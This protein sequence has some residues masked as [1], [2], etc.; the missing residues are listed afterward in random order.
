[1]DFRDG[2]DT[3]IVGGVL[4]AVCKICGRAI[5]K[6]IGVMRKHYKMT[7]AGGTVRAASANHVGYKDMSHVGGET[8]NNRTMRLPYAGS[9]QQE[10][11]FVKMRVTGPLSATFF[12]EP[13]LHTASDMRQS[14]GGMPRSGTS[15]PTHDDCRVDQ[16]FHKTKASAKKCGEPLRTHSKQCVGLIHH[17][18]E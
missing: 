7:H 2:F 14:G 6:N 15:G 8:T 5:A 12:T 9:K 16:Q 11:T 10:P 17:W 13:T 3:G 1:M 4:K 18:T